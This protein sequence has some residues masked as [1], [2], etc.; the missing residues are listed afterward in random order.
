MKRQLIEMVI[1]T[2]MHDE[3]SHALNKNRYALHIQSFIHL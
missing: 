3:V 2:L 1:A